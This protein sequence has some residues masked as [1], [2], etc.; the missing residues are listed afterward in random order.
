MSI[1]FTRTDE[2]ELL[3]ESLEELM[4]GFPES[5]WRQ[6]DDER[7][8]PIEWWEAMVDAGFAFLGI[9][10]E[11]GGTPI[12]AVTHMMFNAEVGRLGGPAHLVHN[13]LRIRDM[14]SFGTEEQMRYTI[15]AAKHSPI[16]FALGA[17]EPQAGSYSKGIT[18][19]AVHKEGK[20]FISGHKTFISHAHATERMLTVTIDDEGKMSMWLVPLNAPGVTM[21]DV[22]KVGLKNSS[23]CEVYLDNVEV[24]ETDVVGEEGN[25]L[26]QLMENYSYERISIAAQALGMA[27][28][29][30]E[31]AMR[32]ANQR[33]QFNQPIAN[34]QLIQQKALEMYLKIENMQNLVYKAA[35]QLDQGI[36]D[37]ILPNAA[38][39]Y[40]T[41]SSFEVID[42]AMQ[43]MGGIGYTDDC[44]ISRLWRDARSMRFTGGTD[45]IMIHVAG[46]GVL[47]SF[48]DR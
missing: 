48:K 9:P 19:K 46:R 39:Y 15:E 20:V 22:H 23:T 13:F 30:Y 35:W 3:L 34:F 44:R 38:K 2:Q 33:E 14:I 18:A 7:K 31:D 24:D 45:E 16:S 21:E 43:I 5:Y 8:L 40:C 10:E 6:C 27:K 17:S 26:Y 28:C 47:K 12:D 32:Y 37:R 11:F 1:D 4:K 25:G 41:R 42:D 29:A 36:D